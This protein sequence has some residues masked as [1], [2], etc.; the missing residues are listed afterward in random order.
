[1]CG[2]VN[3]GHDVSAITSLS[4]LEPTRNARLTNPQTTSEAPQSSNI[5]SLPRTRTPRKHHQPP[6]AGPGVSRCCKASKPPPAGLYFIPS[7][8]G[9]ELSCPMG[10]YR[11]TKPLASLGPVHPS[12]T[13]VPII[14][15]G[16]TAVLGAGRRPPRRQLAFRIV[17][18]DG[19]PARDPGIE[20]GRNVVQGG[21]AF[22]SGV[23]GGHGMPWL[24]R[25]RP[26]SFGP[27]LESC[28]SRRG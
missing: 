14:E 2:A 17:R 18:S 10:R 15:R 27:F 8:G 13:R 16:L 28:V 21:W 5:A 23:G 20:F 3:C 25:P 1:M 12:R 26:L 6:R 7:G 11:P 9:R 4:H 19:K 22:P 24:C